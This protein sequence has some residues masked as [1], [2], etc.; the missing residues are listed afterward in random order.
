MTK[1]F[2]REDI[3]GVTHKHHL[4]TLCAMNHLDFGSAG[5]TRMSSSS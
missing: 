3:G 1:R 5:H 2:D 4:Q